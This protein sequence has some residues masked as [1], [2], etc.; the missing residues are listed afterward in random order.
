[1]TSA[2]VG[3]ITLSNVAG[4][5]AEESRI[6]GLTSNVTSIVETTAIAGQSSIQVND[7]AAGAF[8]TAV[9]LTR[10]KGTLTGASNFTSDEVIEQTGLISYAQARGA[11]HS[12]EIG[13]ST[14]DDIMYISNKFS[15]YNLDP[16][17]VRPITGVSSGAEL[18]SLSSIY[19][20]DLVVGSGQVLYIENLDPITRAGNKSEIIK[21]ILEF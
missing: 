14:D 3:Q 19:P 2:S 11:F 20:G 18:R 8:T 5:F 9:Q 10:L 7:K 15:I 13:G 17:N 4:V 16:G 12:M 6:I 1:V 21:I